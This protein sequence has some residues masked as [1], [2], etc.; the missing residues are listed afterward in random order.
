MLNCKDVYCKD[1]CHLQDLDQ[2]TLEVLETVQAVAE[3]CLPTPVSS[4][5]PGKTVRPGWLD[6]VKPY[7]DKAYF[8]HQLWKSA[9]RPINT[10]LH[11]VMKRT[12]N[13]YHYHYKKCRKAEKLIK[14]NKLLEVCVGG[15]GALFKEVKALRRSPP[16]VATSID[17]VTENVPDHFANLYSNLY[18]SAD[19]TAEFERVHQD[20][21][22]AV[23]ISDMEKVQSITPQLIKEATGKLKPGK[24]DPVYN[25][26]SDCFKNADDSLF[27]HLS[28]ILKSCVVHSHV[29]QVLLLSTL[30]PLI[31][32]KLG[33]IN[34]S[35]NYRSVAISS[36]LLKL[37][38]WVVILLEG[39]AIKLHELQFAYQEQC[40]TVMCTW[41]ALETIDYFLRNGSEVYTCAT[42]MSKAFDLTLHSLMFRKMF[43]AGMSAILIR[44]LMYVYMYQLANVR[45]NGE[46]SSA[47]TVR[48]GCGQGKVLAA[49]AYCMYCEELFETLTRRR[50]GC[51]VMGRFR[52][53]Y[54]YSDDNWLI[55]PSLP[56]L[57][58]MLATCEEFAASH[59]LKF[60][61]DPNPAKCKTK[62][63]AFLRKERVLPSM[64][65]CDNPLPW[66]DKLVHLGNMVSNHIDGGQ[67]DMRQ[68]AARYVEKNCCINQEFSF[69]H[70]T[71]RIILNQIY[72]GHFT[73]CQTWNL[74][75][76]TATSFYSTYNR[77]VKIMANLPF[78]THR[79]LIEPLT[80]HHH[81]SITLIRNFINFINSIRNSKKS[82][83]KQL[84]NIVKCDTRTTTG[85]NLR[86]IL[87]Q[88]NLPNVDSIDMSTV[89]QLKY[90]EIPEEDTWRIP[91]IKEAI[92]I[93]YGLISPPD[94]WSTEELD[95]LL[96][97][98]CTV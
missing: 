18:N 49:I 89:H 53:I 66:V 75:S 22:S 15:G 5:R 38:D 54:G 20:I 41:A 67:L 87:T 24:S 73:G 63:M 14:R 77:S 55:A 35:K 4:C 70:P 40:S 47:F 1:S 61:T 50:S 59:N 2:Y 78:A 84:Y 91:F 82:V 81:M 43:S 39:D 85:S 27:K 69:A 60:S 94:G 48:N 33:N 28:Y 97:H 7:R 83:L 42:D 44:L 71:S 6:E 31:K 62:C 74:F 56:A 45:W 26:S 58:D 80:G 79:Y 19:D 88:T 92:D 32:D 68:K 12:R 57:Q 76:S 23:N 90:K 16:V 21:K 86:N 8:W 93:K 46:V 3:E 52:G 98:A 25:F 30:V 17:G 64:M 37:F 72:N 11:L 95:E 34:S 29:S 13:T 51:W 9:G 96:H 65:L 36:I 10:Q